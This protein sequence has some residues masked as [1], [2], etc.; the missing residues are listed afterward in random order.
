[1]LD[2][3]NYWDL[4][5][6]VTNKQNEPLSIEPDGC[7]KHK[8]TVK[9]IH[10]EVHVPQFTRAPSG[11]E[12]VS[13]KVLFSAAIDE[14]SREHTAI[15]TTLEVPL[16]ALLRSYRAAVVDDAIIDNVPETMVL[17]VRE[18]AEL[19]IGAAQFLSAEMELQK[20]LEKELASV[21]RPGCEA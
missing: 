7:L 6:T 8:G 4:S 5:H 1:M 21:T 14:R 20:D 10:L 11:E 2:L 9:T 12:E 18:I 17:S 13:R 15:P 16:R 19:S 3:A